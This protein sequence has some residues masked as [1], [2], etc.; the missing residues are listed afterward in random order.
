MSDSVGFTGTREGMTVLQSAGVLQLLKG[1]WDGGLRKARHGMC[2]G[3]DEDFH[4]LAR[5]VGFYMIGHPGTRPDGQCFTRA[6]ITCQEKR[7]SFPFVARDRHI[8]Q[9]CLVLIACPRGYAEEQRSG[10]WATVRWARKKNRHL[11]IVQPDGIMLEE[12]A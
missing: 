3:A 12:N 2:V 8:V 10:T 1:M 9:E 4:R 11:Y 7:E 6:A 5:S